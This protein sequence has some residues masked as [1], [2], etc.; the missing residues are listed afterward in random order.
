LGVASG[1][2]AAGVVRESPF[3]CP[4]CRAALTIAGDAHACSACG[5]HYP[6]REG[7]ASFTDDG[8]FYGTLPRDSLQEVIALAAAGRMDEV[9]R[10]LAERKVKGRKVFLRSFEDGFAD[11]R[12]VA[13][14]STGATV[15]DLGCGYG[16]LSLPLARSCARVFALDAT[17]ERVKMVAL[18]ARHEALAN[19]TAVHANA[20]APPFPPDTFDCV[21][22]NGVLEWVGEWDASRSPR[23]VQVGVLRSCAELLKPGG[24]LY[25]A[26]EN[27]WAAELAYRRKDHNKLFWTSFLPRPA[28]DVATRVLKRK[29]Y[30]TFTYGRRALRQLLAAGGFSRVD[31]YCPW[32]RYQNPDF[33]L[34]VGDDAAFTHFRRRVLAAGHPAEARL[35]AALEAAG[36]HWDAVPAWIAVAHKP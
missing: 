31:L 8:Y 17:F 15:L 28:A 20:L 34:R 2:R 16:G 32:P 29:P 23:D 33:V 25:L 10:V 3:A 36:L 11:G 14:I 6:N 5:A 19:L 12:F 27:R 30:R 24:V 35:F 7:V 21:L 22:L 18:R 4:R 26:I 1:D 9:R 13:P